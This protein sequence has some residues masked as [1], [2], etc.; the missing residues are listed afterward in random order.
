MSGICKVICVLVCHICAIPLATPR[1]RLCSPLW[2][3]TY[4]PLCLL[5]SRLREKVLY[6]LVHRASVPTQ[7]P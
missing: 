6:T 5:C 3:E 1:G 7:R 4:I 2:L